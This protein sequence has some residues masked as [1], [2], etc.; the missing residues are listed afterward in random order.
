M[1]SVAI[2]AC[3]VGAD[4]HR[5]VTAEPGPIPTGCVYHPRCPLAPEVCGTTRPHLTET[6]PGRKAAGHLPEEVAMSDQQKPLE[7]RA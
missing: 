2:D 3:A 5:R 4:G 7:V 6:A 1:S